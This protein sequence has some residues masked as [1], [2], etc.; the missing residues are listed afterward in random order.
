[1]EAGFLCS[2]AVFKVIMKLRKSSTFSLE[3]VIVST[4]L[5]LQGTKSVCSV[6]LREERILLRLSLSILVRF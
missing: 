4:L 3:S 2:I 6:A 1:M 5:V